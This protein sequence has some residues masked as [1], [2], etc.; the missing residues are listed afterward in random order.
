M[1]RVASRGYALLSNL[2]TALSISPS[3]CAKTSR[4]SASLCPLSCAKSRAACL[5]AIFRA[6][7][8]LA[9]DPSVC[10]R[11]CRSNPRCVDVRTVV[12]VKCR[13][14]LCVCSACA[15]VRCAFASCDVRRVAVCVRWSRGA[16]T[17]TTTTTAFGSRGKIEWMRL[18]FGHLSMGNWCIVCKYK[19]WFILMNGRHS[20]VWRFVMLQYVQSDVSRR[21]DGFTTRS[22]RRSVGLDARRREWRV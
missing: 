10:F 6:V 4:Q 18:V 13:K 16:A 9:F 14:T 1:C 11:R 7:V 22:A 12:R 21:M 8:D 5:V 17:T 15:P 20:Y 19:V 3:H 2:S